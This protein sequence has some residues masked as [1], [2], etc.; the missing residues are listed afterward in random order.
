VALLV[1][2]LVPVER[3]DLFGTRDKAG[4]EETVGEGMPETGTVEQAGGSGVSAGEEGQAAGDQA[5]EES[6]VTE[7][8]AGE[9]DTPVP[10]E[11]EVATHRFYI[12]AGSFKH[13]GNASELQDRLRAMGYPVEI[14]VTENRMYRVS[15][16]SYDTRA[17]AERGIRE[18]TSD[19]DLKAC[20]LLSNE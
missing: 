4:Q 12:I 16:A 10:Q 3:F 9:E 11:E 5:D 14:M 17:E 1:L 18:I 15:V 7:P 6:M 13:L 8:K 20:W 2:I 19:P